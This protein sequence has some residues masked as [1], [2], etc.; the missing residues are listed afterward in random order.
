VKAL[1]PNVRECHGDEVGVGGWEGKHPHRIGGWG[2]WHK[3]FQRENY[4]SG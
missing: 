3:G 4:E 1:F 2:G